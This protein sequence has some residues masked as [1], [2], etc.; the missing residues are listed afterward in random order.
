[1]DRYDSL[2]ARHQKAISRLEKLNAERADKVNRERELRG[3]IDAL[4][5]SPLVLDA[6]NEQLW[7]LLVVK[8]TVGRD[9]GIKFKYRNGISI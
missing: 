7:M 3:F 1:N 4:A 6:W 9:G 2:V 8:G 5:T